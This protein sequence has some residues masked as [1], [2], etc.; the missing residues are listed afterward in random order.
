MKIKQILFVVL[1]LIAPTLWAADAEAARIV[2]TVGAVQIAGRPA[3][4]GDMVKEGQQL[5]T[6]QDG[7]LYLETVDKGFFILRPNSTGQIVTYQID[8]VNPANTRI[9]L[10]L[11]SG[12]AR[13]ISGTAV[14]SARH[15]F[16]FNT[17]V[18]AV[19]VRGTD[20]TIA[21]TEDTTRIT[22]LSGGVIVSP[23]SATCTP[24]GFGPCEGISSRELFA[25]KV[26]QMLQIGRGL[27]P[28][29]I[30]N[31]EQTPDTLAPPRADEANTI[32]NKTKAQTTGDSGPANQLKPIAST[33]LADQILDPLKVNL[34]SQLT[35]T[36]DT[37]GVPQFIWGRWQAVLD[38]TI[39][40]DVAAYQATHQL[41]ATNAYYALMRSQG[42]NWQAPITS[43]L[44]FSLSQSQAMVTNESTRQVT[45]AKIENAQLTLDFAKSSFFT[46]F[47]LITGAERFTLQNKGEVASDGRLYGGYAFLAP[48]NMDVR[49]ALATDNTSAAYL[50]QARLDAQR[51]ASGATLWGK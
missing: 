6:Q 12:V 30:I 37:P 11:K 32:Q 34:T 36:A 39:E 45:P 48:S 4:L 5:T 49:G 26:G 13:H 19:G 46:K 7:Y 2:F 51:I 29:L 41:L 43:T 42:T 38:K 18:A 25:N 10:E 1:L 44:G 9:K 40:V 23:I 24:G 35:G 33:P 14:Q 31:P 15:N 28:S 50:F 27:T 3:K 47:D 20:F 16:R 8:P 17:P 21:A 22:V